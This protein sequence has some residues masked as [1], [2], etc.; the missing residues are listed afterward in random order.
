MDSLVHSVHAGCTGPGKCY[1]LYTVAYGNEM[2]PTS[3]PDIQQTNLAYTI[4]MLKAMGINDLL[5][6]DFMDPPPVQ[7]MITALESLYA[8]SALD[9]EGLLTC[10]GRKIADFPMDPPLAKMLIASVK[11]GCSKEILSIVAMFMQWLE[12]RK[13]L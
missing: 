7:T 13:F 12:R 11:F 6:F 4:L 10:L 8:L 2:L 1:P 9:N 5:S 3:I